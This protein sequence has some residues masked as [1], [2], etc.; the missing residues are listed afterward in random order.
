[1][2]GTSTGWQAVAFAVV[3]VVVGLATNLRAA[4]TRRP[5]VFAGGYETNP[6]DGARPVAL[7]AGALQVKPEVLRKAF[8]GVTPARGR[9]PTGEEA[10]RN[11]EALLKVLAPYKVT[12]E[13]LDQVSD[14]YRY[15]PERGARRPTS[16]AEA[17]AILEDGTLKRIEITKAGH[18]FN[19]PPKATIQ[20]LESVRLL[21][22][23]HFDK[24]FKKNGAIAM[25]EVAPAME[26]KS[27]QK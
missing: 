24:D 17:F 9:G 15:R 13:R 3:M 10:R 7:V 1:M 25:V 14:Y 22:K 16:P 11:K 12:N 18:G 26:A 6:R 8:G 23:L 2:N 21:V 4:E 20:G 19:A 27:S 5:I